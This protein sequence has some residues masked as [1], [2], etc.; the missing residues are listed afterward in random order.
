MIK[1]C[2]LYSDCEERNDVYSYAG[3][4]AREYFKEI[5]KGESK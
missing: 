2:I 3:R 5:N 1:R 4:R